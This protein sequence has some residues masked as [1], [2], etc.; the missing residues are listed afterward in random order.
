MLNNMQTRAIWGAIFVAVIVAMVT[1]SFLTLF[2]LVL[3]ASTLCIYEYLKMHQKLEGADLFFAFLFNFMILGLGKYNLL[4]NQ[5]GS[6]SVLLSQLSILFLLYFMWQ[7]I[8]F[9]QDAISHIST[10]L[11]GNLYISFPWLL[12]LLMQPEDAVEYQYAWPLSVFILVWA[13]DT[14]A[15][16]V[17]RLLGKR[18]LFKELSPKKTIEGFIGGILFTAITGAL[19]AQIFE[20]YS[21]V[22]GCFLG[23]FVSVFGTMGDLAESAMKRKAGV[24]DSGRILPGHG[25]ALDRF[26]A[27]LFATVAVYAYL[28]FSQMI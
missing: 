10:I 4:L 3:L 2:L 7:L 24:K 16:I 22:H 17:G 1:Y 26:D 27:F 19:L 23:L 6:G 12:L 5:F 20:L 9:K 11:F 8:K 28:V 13:S 21:I 14:F 15:Y 25:G 18:P